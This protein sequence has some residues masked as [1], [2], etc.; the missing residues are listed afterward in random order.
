MISV[1]GWDPTGT[2]SYSNVDPWPY[3]IGVFDLT[4]LTWG[5]GF[6]SS[7]RQYVRSD[8]VDA[9]YAKKCVT[10]PVHLI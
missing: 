3:G 4:A 6:N 5:T 7:A 8:L 9:F 1:G 2:A 10:L